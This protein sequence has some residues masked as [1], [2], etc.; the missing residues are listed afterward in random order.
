MPALALAATWLAAAWLGAASPAAAQD[1]LAL[2]QGRDAER[3]AAEAAARQRDVALANDLARLQAQAD[4]ERALAD[5]AALRARP[6][7][8]AVPASPGAGA[9]VI[10]AGRLAQIPDAALADSDAKVRAAAANRR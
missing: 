6:S 9:P 10:D 5:L 1:N 7:L 4:T 2:T 3:S 8:P